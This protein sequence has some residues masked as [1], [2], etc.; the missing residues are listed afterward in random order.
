MENI[1]EKEKFDESLFKAYLNKFSEEDKLNALK[2][3]FW[4][5]KSEQQF[6]VVEI[7]IDK[8]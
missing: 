6:H 7:G 3:L 1:Q 2:I 5:L 4:S 8:I